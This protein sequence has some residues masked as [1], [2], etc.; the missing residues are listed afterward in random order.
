MWFV[1]CWFLC[2]T[3]ACHM[4]T[5]KSF[6]RLVMASMTWS[7]WDEELAYTCEEEARHW[8]RG[9]QIPQGSPLWSLWSWKDDQGQAS[10]KDYHDYHSSIWIASHGS[11]WHTHYATFTNAASLY[12]FVIV[13]DYSRYT[14]V[15]IVTYKYEV[16]EVFKR[17][18]SRA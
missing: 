6:R 5:C 8:H 14:W 17:F 11:L 1:H 3:T 10:L 7:C 4:S 9:C 12:G 13:D 18:S 2:R 15:H 16:Q